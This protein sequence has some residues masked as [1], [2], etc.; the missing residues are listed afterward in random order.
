MAHSLKDF[1]QGDYATY[2]NDFIG[3]YHEMTART[4]IPD[5]A[6]RA[7]IASLP[8]INYRG[9]GNVSRLGTGKNCAVNWL[10]K[11]FVCFSDMGSVKGFV[12]LHD[13]NWYLYIVRTE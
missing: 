12:Y 5:E 10:N 7:I 11:A 8:D 9:Y 13:F 6:A 2:I 1:K 4:S 3:P